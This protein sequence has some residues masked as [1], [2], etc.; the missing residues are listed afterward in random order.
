MRDSEIAS[1]VTAGDSSVSDGGV[2]S[3]RTK[4][5]AISLWSIFSH[6][7]V[8]V[9]GLKSSCACCTRAPSP[10]TVSPVAK[11][12]GEVRP[13]KL[14]AANQGDIPM[15]RVITA[16]SKRSWATALEAAWSLDAVAIVTV[17]PRFSQ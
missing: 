9:T 17:T 7:E 16:T 15:G 14:V 13:R 2:K 4:K 8:A 12:S 6:V 1:F 11:A 3:G 5:V 10:G